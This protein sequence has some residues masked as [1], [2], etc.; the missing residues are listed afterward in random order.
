MYPPSVG[1]HHRIHGLLSEFP[2]AGDVVVRF[3][4]CGPVAR[5]YTTTD[6]SVGH[7]NIINITDDYVEFRDT[8][9][10]YDVLKLPELINYPSFG[11]RPLLKHCQPTKLRR[12]AET[13]D[14]I[15]NEGPYQVP[16]LA[17][18]YGSTPV[19]YSSHN[20]ESESHEWLRSKPFGDR[21]HRQIHRHEKR[22]LN[23]ADAVICTSNRDRREFEQRYGPISSP[24]LVIPNAVSGSLLRN[25]SPVTSRERLLKRKYDID[26]NV[27]IGLFVGSDYGPNVS[28]ARDVV[29]M[30]S[31]TSERA[32]SVHFFIVGS[33]GDKLDPMHENVTVTGFVEDIEPFFDAAT[34]ALNPIRHGGGTNIKLVDYFARELPVITTEFG[35]RGFD[36]AHGD[37]VL[38]A[39]T[40]DEFLESIFDLLRVESHQSAL[41][42]RA[43]QYV[44]EGFTW[45]VVSRELRQELGLLFE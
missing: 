23:E 6:S 21:L 12:V 2:A 9:V 28:A 14:L 25:S 45:E 13:A 34:F 17:D 44:E 15:I 11:W 40:T 39:E 7:S 18:R 37:E 38:F 36:V 27:P 16:P 1:G 10:V 4:H 32:E 20:V 26:R 29:E 19:I 43:R 3:C 24:I 35:A 41:G 8:S 30:A 31:R 33:V 22:A 5:W 42:Q